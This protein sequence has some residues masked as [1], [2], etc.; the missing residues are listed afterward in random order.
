MLADAK[1][2]LFIATQLLVFEMETARDEEY[3]SARNSD[4]DGGKY[5]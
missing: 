5:R 1:L 4:Y 3:I 2:V